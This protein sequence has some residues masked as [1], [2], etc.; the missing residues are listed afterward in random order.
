MGMKL[1]HDRQQFSQTL[2]DVIHVRTVAALG[3]SNAHG[4]AQTGTHENGIFLSRR[5]GRGSTYRRG[6]AAP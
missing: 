4:D 3:Q 5:G 1:D 2:Q 6:I